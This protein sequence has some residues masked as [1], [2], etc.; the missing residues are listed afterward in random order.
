MLW[1]TQDDI[2]VLGI[3]GNFML[4]ATQPKECVNIQGRR[5]G[6]SQRGEP[7]KNFFQNVKKV[8]WSRNRC[9]SYGFVPYFA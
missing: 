9:F 7:Q 6:G 1:A 3:S 8:I 5:R 2:F 4:M